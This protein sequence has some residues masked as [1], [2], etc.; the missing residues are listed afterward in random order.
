M[1]RRAT[2]RPRTRDAAVIQPMTW[3][4]ASWGAPLNG[5]CERQATPT[6]E[7]CLRCGEPIENWAS[8]VVQSCVTTEGASRRPLHLECFVRGTF[9]SVGHLRGRCSCFGGD[10]ED[11]PGMTR[12]EAARASVLA[13]LEVNGGIEALG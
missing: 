9:G 2:G 11:P 10:E 12:R 4:G 13:L 7:P 6:G 8:G 3:F 5:D 1:G